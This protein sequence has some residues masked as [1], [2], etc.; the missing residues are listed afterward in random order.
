MAAASTG[1][2]VGV[3]GHKYPWPTYLAKLS[4]ALKFAIFAN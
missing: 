1:F 2:S 4:L 3:N